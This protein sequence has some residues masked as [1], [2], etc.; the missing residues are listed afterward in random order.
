MCLQDAKRTCVNCKSLQAT[1]QI[2]T[3]RYKDLPPQGLLGRSRRVVQNIA[4]SL[5]SIHLRGLQTRQRGQ[6]P[7]AMLELVVERRRAVMLL[8]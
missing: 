6:L 3:A 8:F 2:R 5:T 4:D 1:P 7:Q